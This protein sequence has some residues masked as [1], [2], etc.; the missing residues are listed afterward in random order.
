MSHDGT[1]SQTLPPAP[2]AVRARGTSGARC[3]RC[4]RTC[5]STRA[6][7]RVALAFLV[8]AKLAN[9]G[10]PLVLKEIV[11]CLDPTQAR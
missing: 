6:A 3:A 2:A 8:A 7:S 1:I 11:D 9:V 4:C 5:G 10:V